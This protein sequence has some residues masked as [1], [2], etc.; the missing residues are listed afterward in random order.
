M[1]YSNTVNAL[2]TIESLSSKDDTTRSNNELL[3][4]YLSMSELCS[5]LLVLQVCITGVVL[6]GSCNLNILLSFVICYIIQCMFLHNAIIWM[7]DS[8]LFKMILELKPCLAMLNMNVFCFD[9][10]RVTANTMI[11]SWH[12]ISSELTHTHS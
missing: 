7:R 10:I 6:D 12:R 11:G 3:I 4:V 1:T 5:K 2:S 8:C 9:V